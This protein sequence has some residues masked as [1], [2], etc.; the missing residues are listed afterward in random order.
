MENYISEQI[1]YDYS[2]VENA[3]RCLKNMF[4]FE[5]F[6]NYGK[7]GEFIQSDRYYIENYNE[8]IDSNYYTNVAIE[9]LFLT[10]KLLGFDNNDFGEFTNLTFSDFENNRSFVDYF[11]K[12]LRDKDIS[13]YNQSEYNDALLHRWSDNGRTIAT[14]GCSFMAKCSVLSA[15]VGKKISP[16]ILFG[17]VSDDTTMSNVNRSLK[18][19]D[20]LGINYVRY[21]YGTSNGD[22]NKSVIVD[23]L[24][25]G[26]VVEMMVRQSDSERANHV[27]LLTGIS[28][29]G[30][31]VYVNDSFGEMY[32]RKNHK[33]WLI[34]GYPIEKLYSSSQQNSGLG[35]S[36]GYA[37]V[38]DPADN[39]E[40][41]ANL[42]EIFNYEFENL[43][44]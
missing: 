31:Y 19:Y 41:A 15:L 32:D 13:L 3:M 42:Y 10:M 28:E 35:L 29:D 11:L 34:S 9:T 23:A 44:L 26:K 16:E 22:A 2:S 25:S 1:N 17:Y 21:G 7:I 43:Q 30:K 8:I 38:V 5:E 33:D 12:N 6:P 18:L 4:Y 36:N 27:I 24:Q 40:Q 20:I 14:S 37:I 39:I